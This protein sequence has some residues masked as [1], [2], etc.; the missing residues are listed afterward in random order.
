MDPLTIA[1]LIKGGGALAKYGISR[2]Q[3]SKRKYGNTAMGR[4]LDKIR[5][6]GALSEK[7]QNNVLGKQNRTLSSQAGSIQA[8]TQGRLVNQG[9]EGSIAGTRSLAQPNIER[10]RELGYTSRDLTAQNEQSKID[11]GLQYAQG[12]TAY[13]ANTDA[14]EQEANL[15]LA[16]DAARI[17]TEYVAGR[18]AKTQADDAKALEQSRYDT[19]QKEEIMRYEQNRLDKLKGDEN[20]FRTQLAKSLSTMTAEQQKVFIQQLIASGTIQVG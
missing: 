20:A 4:E 7:F 14:M 10:M 2:Y 5:K 1:A 18:Y 3:N 12:A 9:L 8:R 17:G 15:G 13:N 16:S 19:A 6:Q 11:A